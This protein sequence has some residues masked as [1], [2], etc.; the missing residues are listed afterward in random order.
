MDGWLARKLRPQ[1]AWTG[2]VAYFDSLAARWDATGPDPTVTLRRLGELSAL[3]RLKRGED[4]L[5]VGCGT[6]Q[7]TGW[8]V[9]QL[10]LGRVV[11]IDFSEAMLDQA[12]RRNVPAEFRIADVCCDDLGEGRFDVV[13]CFHSFPH[14]RDQSAALKRFARALRPAGRLLVMHLAGSAQISARHAQAGGAVAG[15]RLPSK[16][17]WQSM[18]SAARLEIRE[19]TDREDLFFLATTA[20]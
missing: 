11:A 5:E 2:A 13:L 16:D 14:F 10:G 1:T 4:L 3:L 12:R 8:L 15:D 20:R 7:I 18:L 19:F 6:G 9:D 17:A